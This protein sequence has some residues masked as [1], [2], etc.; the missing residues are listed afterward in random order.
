MQQIETE[1]Q[2]REVIKSQQRLVLFKH[3]TQ[4]PV[5][6]AAYRQ[7]EKFEGM[8]D[9]PV[10]LVRVIEERSLSQ[11]FAKEMSVPHASPQVMVLQAG[12][13]TYTASHYKIQ[14][15]ALRSA[16]K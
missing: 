15:E 12:E 6:A 4:C 16:V 13:V 2:L 7:V 8:T 5:S 3:S 1:A 10:Y 11:Q 9:T 14:A